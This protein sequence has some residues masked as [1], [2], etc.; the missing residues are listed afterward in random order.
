MYALVI[1]TVYLVFQCEFELEELMIESQYIVGIGVLASCS[2]VLFIAAV[3][4]YS[5]MFIF[6]Y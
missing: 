5:D 3:I 4:F 1:I 6:I 2:H